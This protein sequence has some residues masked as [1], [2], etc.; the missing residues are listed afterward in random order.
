MNEL[1]EGNSYETPLFVKRYVYSFTY[2]K[3]EFSQAF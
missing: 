3:Y 2:W 1:K